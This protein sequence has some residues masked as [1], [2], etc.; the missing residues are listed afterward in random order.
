MSAVDLSVVI[1]AFN[2]AGRILPT[3]RRVD[4][5][6]ST[7]SA[8][9]S[10]LVVSDG[11]TDGTDDL[12]AEFARSNSRF[13]LIR[14][15]PNRGK[16]RAVREGML[17][18]PGDLL[19]I[20]DA[21]LATPI[22]EV[23]TLIEKSRDFPVVIGSRDLR[24]SRLEVKQPLPRRLLG[25]AASLL[26]R[27]IGVPGIR[28]TQCGFKLLRRE[29]ARDIFSRCKLN[30]FSFD[31]ELLMIARD[32]G[33]AVAEVPIRWAHQEGSKVSL[34]RDAPRVLIDLVKL[35]LAGRAGRLAVSGSG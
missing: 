33:Y 29:V 30:G 35:R 19:L 14:I 7:L 17:R 31:L 24:E 3:L 23:V 18:A 15:S 6:L 1:P 11:S 21:D 32:L 26:I 10:V 22:E 25:G 16:G 13:A 27:S 9:W 34:W 4:Q 5:F 2:E 12:V 28:D 20:C 8:K